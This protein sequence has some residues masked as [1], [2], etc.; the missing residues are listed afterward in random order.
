MKTLTT[1]SAI[2]FALFAFT[3]TCYAILSSSDLNTGGDGLLTFDDRTNLEWLDAPLSVNRSYNDLV[4][5]D[6]SDEFAIGGDF[7]GFRLAFTGEVRSLFVD[8]LGIP[9][10]DFAQWV[11]GS[12]DKVIALHLLMGTTSGGDFAEIRSITADARNAASHWQSFARICQNGFASVC[13][14]VNT[15]NVNTNGTAIPDAFSNATT[16]AW[17]VRQRATSVPEPGILVLLCIGLTVIGFMR[18]ELHNIR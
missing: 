2:I 14:N 15:A 7:A 12:Y 4:G 10:T 3:S 17:L 1:L 16:G 5:L 13:A 8:T 6:G 18:K 9:L 11:P